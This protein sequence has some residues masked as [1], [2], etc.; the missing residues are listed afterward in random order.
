MIISAITIHG[1]IMMRGA[2][3]EKFMNLDKIVENCGEKNPEEIVAEFLMSIGL[4]ERFNGGYRLTET[5]NKF[6]Q[7]PV[8]K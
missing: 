5:G 6:L 3:V 1:E 8:D 2:M 7:L 4:I